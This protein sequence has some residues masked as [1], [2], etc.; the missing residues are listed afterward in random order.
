[1]PLVEQ[2]LAYPSGAHEFTP[3]ILVEFVLLNL[4]VEFDTTGAT[5]R[6]GTATLSEHIRSTPV[7]SEVLVAEFLAFCL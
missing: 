6:A 1:M 3:R 7:C 2:E 4:S 5:S